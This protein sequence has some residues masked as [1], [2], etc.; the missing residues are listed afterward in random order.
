MS[1]AVAMFVNYR[2]GVT[3]GGGRALGLTICDFAWAV[4]VPLGDEGASILLPENLVAGSMSGCG[5]LVDSCC[6][7]VA[8]FTGG[9]VGKSLT[10]GTFGGGPVGGLPFCPMAYGSV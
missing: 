4:E 7:P 5:A 6:F 2:G 8:D 1:A 9:A 10:R 3:L